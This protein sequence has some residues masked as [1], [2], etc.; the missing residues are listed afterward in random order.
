MNA[1]I[2]HLINSVAL[3][4][5][6]GLGYYVTSANSPTALIP[7]F[8]GVVLL[9]LTNGVKNENKAIAHVA[10]VLTLLILV[11]LIIKPL[12]KAIGDNDTM[13]TVRVGIMVFT[14]FLALVYFIKSFIDARKARKTS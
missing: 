2:A 9:S 13:G 5:I 3:I 11:A 14:S 6:G 12:L 8:V 1:Y 4:L 7:V 10:V